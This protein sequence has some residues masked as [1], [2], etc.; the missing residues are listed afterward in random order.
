MTTSIFHTI[1]SCPCQ[2]CWCL[3]VCLT[4][5]QLQTKPKAPLVVSCHPVH[6]SWTVHCA[7]LNLRHDCSFHPGFSDKIWIFTF[8]NIN[9]IIIYVYIYTKTATIE[10]FLSKLLPIPYLGRPWWLHYSSYALANHLPSFSPPVWSGNWGLTGAVILLGCIPQE[11][12]C[13]ECW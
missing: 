5:L 11:N 2:S 6:F 3:A 10:H 8:V 4:L 1:S 7:Q 12:R 13:K 9:Y